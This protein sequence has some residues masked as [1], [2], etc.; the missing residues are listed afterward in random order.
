MIDS[1]HTLNGHDRIRGRT[2]ALGRL[3]GA[4]TLILAFSLAL[5][6]CTDAESGEDQGSEAV[7]ADE[8][9]PATSEA[10]DPAPILPSGS[11]LT[12]EVTNTVSTESATEGDEV[13]LRLVEAV[14]GT[15]DGEL[16]AGTRGV[17]VVT[18]SHESDSAEEQAVLALQVS[19][20]R[21]NGEERPLTGTIESTETE[22]AARSSGQRSVATVATGAAAGAILGQILG[23]DT[24]STAAGAAVGAAA[25]LGVALSTRDGHAVLPEGALITVRLTEPLPLR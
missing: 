3:G 11:M 20:V 18:E 23:G 10:P 7:S 14:S 25:G 21:V 1:I 4:A 24:R 16:A 15:E 9:A 6:G 2:S 8:S 17:A 19:T 12:F 13:E 5:G 22:A